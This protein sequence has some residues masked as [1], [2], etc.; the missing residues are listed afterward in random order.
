LKEYILEN[1]YLKVVF[2]D[3][4]AIIHQLWIKNE[5][6]LSIN[7]I[8]GLETPEAYLEDDWSRGAIIGRFAGRLEN[9][10]HIEGIPFDIEHKKGVLLHSGKSGWNSKK[11]EVTKEFDKHM[12]HFSY[13]CPHQSSGFPGEVKAIITY[14]IIGRNFYVEYNATTTESTH[15]NLTNHTYFN[16]NPSG[17]INTQLLCIESKEILLLK[18]TLVPTGHKKKVKNTSFDYQ[19]PKLIGEKSLDDYFVLNTSAEK[20]ASIYSPHSGIE[21]KVHT[22]QPGLVV[23]MPSHF[24]AI[25]F[26]TQKFS[27]TPNIDSFPSTLI[28][29]GEL[30]NHKT[31]FEFNLKNDG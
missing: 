27:N 29:P 5:D 28:K 16:V 17:K 9:P 3:Y 20:A 8:N 31:Y 25:C 30:Y 1:K 10:I 2:L 13:T 24:E 18:N 15:I 7:V 14:S 4:G 11:W 6:G 23:F 22:N 21:M 26:E 19:T 12:L